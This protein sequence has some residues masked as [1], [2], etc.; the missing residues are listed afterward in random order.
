MVNDYRAVAPT[1][2]RSVPGRQANLFDPRHS[3]G[4]CALA[5]PGSRVGQRSALVH[6]GPRCYGSAVT[7]LVAHRARVDQ[8]CAPWLP[9]SETTGELVRRPV[10][11]A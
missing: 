2:T 10:D 1:C 4:R 6:V 9:G 5:V 11:L 8:L 7:Q 3:P